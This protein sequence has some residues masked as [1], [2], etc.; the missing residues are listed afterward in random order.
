MSLHLFNSRLHQSR[1]SGE[2]ASFRQEILDSGWNNASGDFTF[3][4]F[5]NHI[6]REFNKK[7]NGLGLTGLMF[8]PYD[9]AFRPLFNP[10]TISPNQ[11][12]TIAGEELLTIGGQEIVLI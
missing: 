9:S 2:L 1:S 4:M 3:Q 8:S 11:I 10:D 6:G 5:S 12:L 7:A